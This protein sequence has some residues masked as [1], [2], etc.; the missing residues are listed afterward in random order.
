MA[1]VVSVLIQNTWHRHVTQQWPSFS[2][3]FSVLRLENPQITRPV[4]CLGVGTWAMCKCPAAPASLQGTCWGH[5]Q[6]SPAGS[7]LC[8]GSPDR[9]VPLT[10]CPRWVIQWEAFLCWVGR[11]W[12]CLCWWSGSSSHEKPGFNHSFPQCVS[13]SWDQSRGWIVW[14]VSQRAGCYYDNKMKTN[15]LLPIIS[16]CIRFRVLRFLWSLLDFAE[17]NW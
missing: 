7:K 2:F 1:A 3:Q 14:N 15:L 8:V 11:A 5:L 17:G 16:V 6:G 10:L 13:N 12:K 9:I 4:L